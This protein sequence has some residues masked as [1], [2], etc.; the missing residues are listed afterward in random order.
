M[1]SFGT[2]FKACLL[3]VHHHP[4]PVLAAV[5]KGMGVVSVAAGTAC[6]FHRGIAK[7]SEL[8]YDNSRLGPRSKMWNVVASTVAGS[9]EGVSAGITSP[10]SWPLLAYY[11]FIR[12]SEGG[13]HW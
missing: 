9:V 2:Y 10:L 3:R 7:N 6:G 8:T 4:N 1:T 11:T 13:P 12:G 5:Y